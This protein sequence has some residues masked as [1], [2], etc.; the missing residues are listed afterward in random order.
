M[1][2]TRGYKFCYNF[3]HS[4]LCY[5]MRIIRSFWKPILWAII[6][7]GL[8]TMSGRKVNEIP[9]MQIHY[10]D[11]IAHFTMYFIFTFLMLYDFSRYKMKNLAWKKIIGISILVAITFGGSMELLQEVPS[12]ERSTD[13]KDFIANSLG[14][15]GAVVSYKYINGILNKLA[16]I[17]I[18]PGNSYS[19]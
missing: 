19:L 6:V 11:K 16:S 2:K 5:F 8:S 17:F 18:K 13:I 7:L 10:M 15:L 4:I 1:L 12:M 9:L 3:V 14:A